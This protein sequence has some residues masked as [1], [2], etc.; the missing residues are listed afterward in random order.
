MSHAAT[1]PYVPETTTSWTVPDLLRRRAE[2]Q[3]GRIALN[4]NDEAVMTYGEWDQRSNALAHGLIAAGVRHGQVVGLRY[5]DLDWIDYAIAYLGVL[6]AGATAIHLNR[7]VGAQETMRRLTWCRAV[8]V[9]HGAG[10]PPPDEFTGVTGTVAELTGTDIGEVPVRVRVTDIADILFTSGTTGLAKASTSPHGNLTYGRGPEGF[11]L[12][13]DPEPLLTPMPLGTT[14]SA[15]TMSF[16]VH[17]PSTLVLC[18]TDDPER[19]AQLIER[20][21]IG[22]VMITPWL[23]LQLLRSGAGERYDLSCVETLAN[24]STALPPAVARRLLKIMPN[25]RINMSYAAS[26]A[27]PASIGHTFDPA[28]PLATGRPVRNTEL[29]IVGD[30]G[31]PVPPGELGEIWLRSPAPKRYYFDNPQLNERV[32]ADRWTRTGDLGRVDERG[33]LYFFDRRNVAIRKP[34]GLVSTIEV[35]AALY[36]HP[37]VQEAAVFGVDRDGNP[38]DQDVVA[39]VVLG[40]AAKVDEL[41]TF[42][43]EHLTA[44]QLPVRI[45]VV[46][47]MPRSA[48][49]KVLKHELREQVES[50]ASR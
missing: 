33:M 31:A 48:N 37:E 5:D 11:Y 40:D 7:G 39:A 28:D 49:G 22:S 36:E 26:E 42:L 38:D 27:V 10:N 50:G 17:T 41:P 45:H 21:R 16:S 8:A 20:F 46:E 35:E 9:V 24:A 15:T 14:A 34:T 6:K 23:A 4:V 32:H 1:R 44:E 2:L 19:M 47:S 29:R 13:G 18:P 3:P 30:D 43:R 12:F 25:A